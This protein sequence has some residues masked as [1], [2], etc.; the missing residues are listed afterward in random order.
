MP[1]R[2]DLL[3]IADQ[4]RILCCFDIPVLARPRNDALDV[5][6]CEQLDRLCNLLAAIALVDR[7]DIHVRRKMFGQFFTKTGQYIDDARGYV[8]CVQ[9]FG[10]TD[11]AQRPSLRCQHNAGIATDDGRRDVRNQAEQAAVIGRQNCHN[12]G[13][14]EDREIEM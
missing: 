5:F 14:L 6:R 2:L 3:R 10:K 7:V 13:W 11:P 12:T 8:G 1:G 9:H 4:V